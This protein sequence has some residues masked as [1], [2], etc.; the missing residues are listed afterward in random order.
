MPKVTV[1]VDDKGQIHC[2]PE[3]LEVKGKSPAIQFLLV[4]DGHV[5]PEKEAVVLKKP[6]SDF[7]DPARTV[8]PKQVNLND[9]NKTKGLF[10][11][12]VTV[13]AEADGRRIELDPGVNNDGGG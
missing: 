12:S 5:F 4:T 9:L 10:P 7:P 13:I 1:S 6:S 3:V 2:E 11:Y 8:T